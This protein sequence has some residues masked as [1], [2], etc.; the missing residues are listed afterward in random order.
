MKPI[1]SNTCNIL[2][3]KPVYKV[4]KNYAVCF[5]NTSIM[6]KGHNDR[7]CMYNYIVFD[8]KPSLVEI[9]EA[10]EEMFNK[11][12][13]NMITNNFVY[14]GNNISLTK[15]NQMNYK[16]AYDLAMQ[17]NGANLPY[18]IKASKNGVRNYIIFENTVEFTQFYVAMNKFI[19]K[20]LEDGWAAKD[21]IDYSVYVQ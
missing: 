7:I 13:E 2:D 16:A 17:T 21:A 8:S 3:Y 9:K 15:E 14:D 20:C 12:T 10:F 5:N 11:S 19:N 18:K 4:G 6:S 1:Y